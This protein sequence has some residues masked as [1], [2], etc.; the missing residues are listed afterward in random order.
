VVIE[1]CDLEHLGH[2]DVHLARQ[3][4]QVRLAQGAEAVVQAVQVLDQQ[5]A[6]V[7]FGRAVAEAVAHFTEGPVVGLAPLELAV[8]AKALAQLLLG[9]QRNRRHARSG[10]SGIHR[11]ALCLHAPRRLAPTLVAD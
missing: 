10:R 3:R 8:A 2:R 1:A 11:R 5:V 6:A 7:A 4:H 9:G